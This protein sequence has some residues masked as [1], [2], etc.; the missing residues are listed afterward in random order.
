M[1]KLLINISGNFNLVDFL[2]NYYNLSGL[3]CLG[4]R[5]T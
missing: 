3:S 4:S 2:E 1:N 5:I